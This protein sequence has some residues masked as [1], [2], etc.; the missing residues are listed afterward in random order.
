MQSLYNGSPNSLLLKYVAQD[1]ANYFY[2]ITSADYDNDFTTEE[3]AEVMRR[4]SADYSKVLALAQ[5][6]AS[7][8]RTTDRDFWMTFVGFLQWVHGDADKAYNT[9]TD[10]QYGGSLYGSQ[11]DNVRCIRLLAALDMQKKPADFDRYFLSEYKYIYNKVLNSTDDYYYGS[12]G[13]GNV[14][15]DVFSH[16]LALRASRYYRNDTF[17]VFIFSTVRNRL[18]I[19]GINGFSAS[20]IRKMDSEMT[21][22]EVIAFA[23]EIHRSGST[24]FDHQLYSI[25]ASKLY[26]EDFFNEFIGTKLIRELRFTEAAKYLEKVPLSYIQNMNIAPYLA[27]R[28]MPSSGFMHLQTDCLDGEEC[29]VAH[30]YKLQFAQRMATLTR[31]V[32]EAVGEEKAQLAY[33]MAFELYHASA[34][35]D[36][37]ALSNYSRSSG[38]S[39]NEL[40]AAAANSLRKAIRVTTNRD[41][42]NKCY[43]ALASIPYSTGR[44]EYGWYEISEVYFSWENDTWDFRNIAGWQ[45]DGYEGLRNISHSDPLYRSCDILQAYINQH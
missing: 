39:Y 31:Q 18:G 17:A 25:V 2:R 4:V 5:R 32:D 27:L 22:D 35:G 28:K 34:D 16:E 24:A 33:R 15:L 7:D 21:A 23:D 19:D 3:T 45:R 29:V 1:Y 41:L 43:F 6:I 13:S 11:Q 10:V 12:N 36:M 14:V 8:E 20:D 42:R 9:L 38:A 37:W 40:N 30:N 26:S 44:S